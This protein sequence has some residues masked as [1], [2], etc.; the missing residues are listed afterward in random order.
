MLPIPD[1]V[2]AV[3]TEHLD[4]KCVTTEK[5]RHKAVGRDKLGDKAVGR[6]QLGDKAVGR[7]QLGSQVVS[8]GH[9]AL[10]SINREHIN[11]D[12]IPLHINWQS[13]EL[14]NHWENNDSEGRRY[15]SAGF[16]KDAM[17]FVHLKGVVRNGTDRIIFRLPPSY[18]PVPRE[19]RHT[20]L[21]LR[22]HHVAGESQ[23]HPQLEFITILD[24]GYVMISGS[25]SEWDLGIS[26][27][28]I[29][30]GA[31]SEL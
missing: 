30:F 5:L 31:A 4:D 9:I 21:N 6:D 7:S 2:G 3:K 19:E 17:G 11:P 22:A 14:L 24:D 16:C 15:N 29:T 26:L 18:R 20:A 8:S 27:D 12:S 25:S 28:G 10:R 1:A 13:A 23:T